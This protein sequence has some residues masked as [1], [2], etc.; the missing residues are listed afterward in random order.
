MA[1]VRLLMCCLLF[2]AQLSLLS[3]QQVILATS[4]AEKFVS[5]FDMLFYSD[6]PHPLVPC[7][8]SCLRPFSKFKVDGI[9]LFR[10]TP[11]RPPELT[12][13]F[14]FLCDVI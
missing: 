13:A 11:T 2:Q 6:V 1:L 5:V 14:A 12:E 4:Q 10:L 9:M 7:F 8:G 3:K